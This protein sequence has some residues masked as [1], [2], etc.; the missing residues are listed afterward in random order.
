[1]NLQQTN[2]IETLSEKLESLKIINEASSK[3]NEQSDEEMS[4]ALAPVTMNDNI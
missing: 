2:N 3:M 4:V 1:M